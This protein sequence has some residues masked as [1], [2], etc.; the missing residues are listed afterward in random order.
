MN[1]LEFQYYL[2]VNLIF[3]RGTVSGPLLGGCIDVFPM[4]IGTAASP[5]RSARK[6]RNTAAV[7]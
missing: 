4:V 7:P 2:P 1:S 3:G 6:P 5:S